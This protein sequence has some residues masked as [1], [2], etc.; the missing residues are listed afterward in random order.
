MCHI[1]Q[2]YYECCPNKVS[3]EFLAKCSRAQNASRRAGCIYLKI[4]RVGL[5]GN[6]CEECKGGR[7]DRM[8]RA[9]KKCLKLGRAKVSSLVEKT[10]KRG[11]FFGRGS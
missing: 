3:R 5:K 11:Q 2:E 4:D 6:D 9:L 7:R 10:K 1:F 8:K